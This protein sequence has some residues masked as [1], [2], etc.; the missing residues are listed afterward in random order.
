MIISFK[1]QNFNI[2]DT[3]CVNLDESN[4][5][6]KAFKWMRQKC[7]ILEKNLTSVTCACYG[8]GTFSLTNDLYDPNVTF[9]K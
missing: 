2:S 3:R 6:Q 9:L 1:K 8:T 7:S 4:E 5:S